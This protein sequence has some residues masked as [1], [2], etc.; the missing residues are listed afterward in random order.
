MFS[1]LL[2]A[3]H[4]REAIEVQAEEEFDDDEVE[5]LDSIL[6]EAVIAMILKLNDAIFRP[7]FVRLVD[8]EGPLPAKPQRAITFYK[9]LAAFFDKFK[10]YRP[11]THRPPDTSIPC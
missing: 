4:L 5:Q 8:Q 7:F 9:F 1:V 3:F 2:E 6:V 10:V 11:S